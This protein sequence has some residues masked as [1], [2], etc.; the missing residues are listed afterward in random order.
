M[1]ENSL[2]AHP[3][4]IS[5]NNNG[6]RRLVEDP[7]FW[8]GFEAISSATSRYRIPLRSA[9]R[10]RVLAWNLTDPATDLPHKCCR[11]RSEHDHPLSIRV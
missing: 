4:T 10:S 2:S 11:A 1:P 5:Q 3:E 9:L 7:R 8:M 6:R